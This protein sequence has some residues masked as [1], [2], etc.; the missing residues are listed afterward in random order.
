MAERPRRSTPAAA[1]ASVRAP[2]PAPTAPGLLELGVPQGSALSPL[3]SNVYLRPFDEAVLAAGY[4]LVRYADDML[5]LGCSF[6]ETGDALD[7]LS[8][9]AE[10]LGLRLGPRKTRR[11]HLGEGFVFLGVHFGPAGRGPAR[12]AVQ[13][14][15][16]RAAAILAEEADPREAA[17]GLL[18]LLQ[19]W[20]AYQGPLP[21]SDHPDA[22]VL[23]GSLSQP[24]AQDPERQAELLQA[25]RRLAGSTEPGP[26]WLYLTL[27]ESWAALGQPDGLL[28]GTA[29][30]LATSGRRLDPQLRGWLLPALAITEADAPAVL[31]GLA[32]PPVGLAA[33]LGRAGRS[34]LAARVRQG[35]LGEPGGEPVAG[36]TAGEAAVPSNGL[37]A[38]LGELLRGREG[39]H[40]MLLADRRGHWRL[41]PV[42]RKLDAEGWRAHLAG[43][44]TLALYPIGRDQTL[45]LAV[46]TVRLSKDSLAQLEQGSTLLAQLTDAACRLSRAAEKLGLPFLI[47]EAGRR[48]R[49]IW[50]FF[51]E[52]LAQRDARALLVRL[53]NELGPL[54]SPLALPLLPAVD[55]LRS[56]PGPMVTLPLAGRGLGATPARLLD[57][58]VAGRW[59]TSRLPC[60]HCSPSRRSG[61]TISCAAGRWPTGG[62]AHSER[63]SRWPPSC[64]ICPGRC[65][66]PSAAPC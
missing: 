49:R 13:A 7:L 50:L 22:A 20:E 39:L 59:P 66:W 5:V 40:A 10:A 27:A 1:S 46:A 53:A 62:N 29:A 31:D 34:E 32:H 43:R 35:L 12:K 61:S 44:R 54:E 58:A 41:F 37:L 4:P 8:R 21:G 3:L 15:A 11:G 19:R 26:A 30:L 42:E 23:L 6:E 38:R 24:S 9:Q 56:S 55:R 60:G 25:C 17:A 14:L 57:T 28:L 63:Q 33:A 16:E 52:P 18:L 65:G 2:A 36:S 64:A 51:A 48:E 47:E 45:R